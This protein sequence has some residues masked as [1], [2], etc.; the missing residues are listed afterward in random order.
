MGGRDFF[1]L[2]QGFLKRSV[3]ERVGEVCLLGQQRGP[4]LS[5]GASQRWEAKAQSDSLAQ[6]GSPPCPLGTPSLL[7]SAATALTML[8]S[9]GETVCRPWGVLV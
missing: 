4:G 8:W 9:E 6:W 7:W 2:C 3:G 5:P 1:R